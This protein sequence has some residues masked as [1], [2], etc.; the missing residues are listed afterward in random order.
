MAGHDHSHRIR[1]VRVSDG[2][3]RCGAADPAGQLRV[4][5]RRPTRDR[6]Q[7][8]PHFPLEGRAGGRDRQVV[9]AFEGSVE[10]CGE[11]GRQPAGVAAP[12]EGVAAVAVRD[13]ERA[14]EAI[15][16]I[17][18]TR[19]AQPAF[20]VGDED[21]LADRRPCPVREE[22]ETAQAGSRTT[23]S[24][25]TDHSRPGRPCRRSD[26]N[27]ISELAYGHQEGAFREYSR[28]LDPRR[29]PPGRSPRRPEPFGDRPRAAGR[30]PA[31]D[32]TGRARRNTLHGARRS[33]AT[34]SATRSEQPVSIYLPAEYAASPHRRFPTVYLLHG[35]TG[36]IEEWTTDGYQGM[37]LR[38]DMDELIRTRGRSA[39]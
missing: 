28:T 8:L 38:D 33:R 4:G 1:A 31:T 5:E 25:S 32:R 26:G 39:R 36:K 27:P 3:D 14:L 6:A 9:N 29:P 13:V 23:P 7:R 37:N 20:G 21:Q 18:P 35:Y 24:P 15:L 12:L 19:G 22:A 30:P 16:V 10:I 11:R 17:G 2:S 34:S